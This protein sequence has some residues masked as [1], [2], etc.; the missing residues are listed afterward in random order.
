MTKLKIAMA[1]IEK[2]I[3]DGDCGLFFTRNFVGDPMTLL[4]D[5]GELYIGICYKYSY[6]E[7]FGLSDEDFDILAKYYRFIR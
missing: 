6:F 2:N 5:D 7:V 1:V 3:K 4:Y